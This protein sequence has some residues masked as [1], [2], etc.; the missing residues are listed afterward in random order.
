MGNRFMLN[1]DI[2]DKAKMLNKAIS[3]QFKTKFHTLVIGS[4]DSN[5]NVRVGMTPCNEDKLEAIDLIEMGS[6]IINVG[7]KLGYKK[8][9]A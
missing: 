4:I 9:G 8:S 1:E 5:G 6:Y 7:I 2:Q 3:R